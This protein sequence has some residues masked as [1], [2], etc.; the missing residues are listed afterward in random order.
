MKNQFTLFVM[1]LGIA[2]AVGTTQLS[3]SEVTEK[4][5]IPFEFQAGASHMEA[6]TYTVSTSDRHVVTVSNN[7]TGAKRVVGLGIPTGKPT[8]G[9][10]MLVFRRYGTRC[11]LSEIWYPEGYVQALPTSKLEQ[12]VAASLGKPE[13][14]QI[15]MR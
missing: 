4:G 3:A 5:S 13:V 12:E 15:A 9:K 11:F 6:G 7:E 2:A 14:T 1:S 8:S 10:A